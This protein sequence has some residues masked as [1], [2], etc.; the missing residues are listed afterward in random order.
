LLGFEPLL[1]ERTKTLAQVMNGWIHTVTEQ[2]CLGC[3]TR[4]GF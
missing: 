3:L 4:L 1:A 2:L